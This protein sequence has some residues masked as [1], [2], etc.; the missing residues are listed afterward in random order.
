MKCYAMNTD[1]MTNPHIITDKLT[2]LNARFSAIKLKCPELI[3]VS[4]EN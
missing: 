4:I 2:L 1:F 3:S